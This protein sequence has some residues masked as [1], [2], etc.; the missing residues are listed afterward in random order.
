MV[1]EGRL[2][3]IVVNLDGSR[4]TIRARRGIVLASGGFGADPKWR[5]RYMPLPDAHISVQPDTNVGDG[6]RLGQAAGGA[7]GEDNPDNGGMGPG[8]RSTPC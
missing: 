6:I 8:F 2:E 4:S 7:L 1:S 3:A 5:E